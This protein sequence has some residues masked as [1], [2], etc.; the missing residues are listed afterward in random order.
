VKQCK[1]KSREN[2]GEC[3]AEAI[4]KDREKESTKEGFFEDRPEH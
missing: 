4:S 1:K 3:L 2:D